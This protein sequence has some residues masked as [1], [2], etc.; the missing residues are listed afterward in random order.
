[1]KLRQF[2]RINKSDITNE[3]K[4]EFD[5]QYKERIAELERQEKEAKEQA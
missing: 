4:E 2:I 3:E 5:K 1:M